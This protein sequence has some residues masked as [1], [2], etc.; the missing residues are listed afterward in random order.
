MQVG[1][2]MPANV[3]LV[4]ITGSGLGDV[5]VGKSTCFLYDFKTNYLP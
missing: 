3:L 5:K 4:A 2:R 1:L